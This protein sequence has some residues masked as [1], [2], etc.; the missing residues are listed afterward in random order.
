MGKRYGLV[1]DLENCVGCNACTVACRQENGEHIPIGEFRTKVHVIESGSF[2]NVEKVFVK[3]GCMHCAEAPC[4]EACPQDAVYKNAE[5]ITMI[6]RENC[7]FCES[8]VDVCPYHAR[9]INI[10]DEAHGMAD[11]CNFC[12]DRLLRG[13]SPACMVNCVG[14]ALTFGDLNDPGSEVSKKAKLARP[15]KADLKTNPSVLYIP[16]VKGN[17]DIV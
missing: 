5:G 9:V 15:L 14:R 17:W 16:P 12:F 4:I 6:N 10:M 7:I 3:V 1:I 11:G 13:D 8:C 2:P